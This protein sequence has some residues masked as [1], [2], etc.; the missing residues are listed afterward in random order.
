MSR[1]MFGQMNQDVVW[2][3]YLGERGVLVEVS[4]NNSVEN[5]RRECDR[6]CRSGSVC[7]AIAMMWKS[8]C[9]FL[10]ECVGFYAG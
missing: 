9:C 4:Q 1:F 2:L 3:E 10:S 5:K 8:M 6:C 7:C